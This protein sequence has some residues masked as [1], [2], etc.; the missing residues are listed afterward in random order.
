MTTQQ[1]VNHAEWSPITFLVGVF[2]QSSRAIAKKGLSNVYFTMRLRGLWFGSEAGARDCMND[3]LEKC[4]SFRFYP[5][6]Q[7]R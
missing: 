6:N 5:T 1:S 4:D 7:F 2:G 3:V